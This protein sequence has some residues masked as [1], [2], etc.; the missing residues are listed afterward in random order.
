VQDSSEVAERIADHL[1]VLARLARDAKLDAL[2]YVIAD[3]GNR[4]GKGL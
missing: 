2:A 1:V 4:S 3:R